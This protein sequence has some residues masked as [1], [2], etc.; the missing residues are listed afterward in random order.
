MQ[1]EF[2]APPGYPSG[3]SAH[4]GGGT[5]QHGPFGWEVS[6]RLVH[7]FVGAELLPPPPKLP[8]GGSWG[9]VLQPQSTQH[10]NPKLTLLNDPPNHRIRRVYS[11]YADWPRAWADRSLPAAKGGDFELRLRLPM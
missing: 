5:G 9:G 3:L 1:K 4:W 10:V 8:A 6:S 2:A 7:S 11:L